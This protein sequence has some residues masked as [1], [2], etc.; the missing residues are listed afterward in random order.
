MTVLPR[1]RTSLAALTVTAVGAA[2]AVVLIV[3][4]SYQGALWAVIATMTLQN[5]IPLF[6]RTGLG[7]SPPARTRITR[8]TGGDTDGTR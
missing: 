5:A 1:D 8:T 4:G 7:A 2:V 3:L 6:R